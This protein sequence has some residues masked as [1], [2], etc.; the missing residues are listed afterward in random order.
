M[1]WVLMTPLGLPVEPEVNRIFATVSGARR[2][3]ATS[4][5]DPGLVSSSLDTGVEVAPT[6]ASAGAN[7]SG[8]AAKTRPGLSSSKMYLSLAKSFDISE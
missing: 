3:N 4:S 5:V 8:S 1:R 7:F 2:E 6:A